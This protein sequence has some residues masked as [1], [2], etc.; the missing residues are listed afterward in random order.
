MHHKINAI[1]FDLPAAI[2]SS[3]TNATG[4]HYKEM[5]RNI[6]RRKNVGN[7]SLIQ[8]LHRELES[9]SEPNRM[10]ELRHQLEIELKK[11]PNSTH[12]TVAQY[13]DD[14]EPVL[15]ASYGTQRQFNA[16]KPRQF[17]ELC[18][19]L[20]ILRTEHL[21]HFTGAKTYYLLNEL[22]EL[23]CLCNI[24]SIFNNYFSPLVRKKLSSN[25]QFDI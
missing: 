19:Q 25:L 7:I 15:I 24:C 18:K 12:P 4:E 1:Q 14:D 5:E 11:L 23:V 8:H 3:T 21:G 17:A 10:A 9:T 2:T 20:N 16:F 6:V 13:P 22:A